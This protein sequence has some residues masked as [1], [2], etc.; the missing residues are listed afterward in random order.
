MK[1]LISLILVTLMILSLLPVGVLSAS[2]YTVT[3]RNIYGEVYD[4][5]T[6]SDGTSFTLPD[7]PA[8]DGMV[9][10]GWKNPSGTK[11]TGSITVDIDYDLTAMYQKRP[12][13]F[14]YP[15]KR[16]AFTATNM[17]VADGYI[18]DGGKEWKRMTVIGTGP[19]NNNYAFIFV[20]Y[21]DIDAHTYK[22]VAIGY[23]STISTSYS[24]AIGPYLAN[25]GG[26]HRLWGMHPSFTGGNKPTKAV[27]SLESLTGGDG[28]VGFDGI[29]AD[30]IIQALR[31]VPWGN[32]F[33]R[34][35]YDGET[36]DIEYI[37]FFKTQEEAEA[38]EYSDSDVPAE[39]VDKPF[40]EYATDELEFRPDDYLTRAEA[41]YA[42]KSI[43]GENKAEYKSFAATN[44][45]SSV[46]KTSLMMLIDVAV[47]DGELVTPDASFIKGTYVT[48]AEAAKLLSLADGRTPTAYGISYAG[49]VGRLS[50]VPVEHEYFSYIMEACFEHDAV[51]DFDNTELWFNVK[52]NNVYMKKADSGLVE[53]LNKHM[54]SRTA[55][56]LA[57]ESEWTLGSGGKVIY[58]S[59]R[60][61]DSNDGLSS[62]APV[63]TLD[64]VMEMQTDGQIVRGDVVLFERGGE[65]Y[66]GYSLN[67]NGEIQQRKFVTKSGVTYSA[68]GS[69][70]KPII[71][72]SFQAAGADNWT[73]V[74]GYDDLWYFNTKIGDDHD[75]GN[76]VFNKGTFTYA[77]EG[78]NITYTNGAGF[79]ARVIK[80]ATKDVPLQ[81]GDDKDEGAGGNYVASNGNTKW[82]FNASEHTFTTS[83]DLAAYAE[84]IPESDLW[85][86]HNKDES[87]LYMICKEGN[88][89][90]VFESIDL[91][92][93]GHGVKVYSGVT[94]DNLAI[95][96]T[97]SHGVSAGSC[98]NLTVRNCE[99]GYIGGSISG[100]EKS[101]STGR[102]GNAVEIYGR[103]DGYYVYNNYMYQC[104]DCG[105][106]VQAGGISLKYNDYAIAQNIDIYDNVLWNAALEVWFTT[107]ENPYGRYYAALINCKLRDNLVAFNGYGFQGY[108][109]QNHAYC[110]FYGASGT[111]ADYIDCVMENNTFWN[112]RNYVFKAVPTTTTPR[113]G[114][115]WRN[116]KIVFEYG[117]G[118]ALIGYSPKIREG[119]IGGSPNPYTNSE[120]KQILG[121]NVLGFNEFYYTLKPGQDDPHKPYGDVNGDGEITSIDLVAIVRGIAGWSEYSE[122]VLNRHA[123]V[124]NNGV[125]TSAD[126]VI[127]ARHLSGWTGYAFL[128]VAR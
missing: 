111:K 88:P 24:W 31:M 56:V 77:D 4:T 60:G 3:L 79:G 68:Y 57:T 19:N 101:G 102:F 72:G 10:V 104:F 87:R 105:P 86:H 5:K 18:T 7:A 80:N 2:T 120:L 51:L 116:N 108:T 74:E 49:S 70:D 25:N 11:L 115:Y 100:L 63:A 71:N 81:M 85:Y 118:F 35:A 89:G 53:N 29:D 112:M 15:A 41:A 127:L 64:K 69:G 38:Y 32:A 119:S 58:V 23:R 43:T 107:N 55:E 84:E 37:A 44:P 83:T 110:G 13:Y 33:T 76:I 125:V 47:D 52:D 122:Y 40:M 62:S 34:Y 65:W 98:S 109:H 46:T 30:S 21:D 123:D 20:P 126:A 121:Y 124:D 14:V 9:H 73:K 67:A 117:K 42:L 22:Y 39:R 61:S 96:F 36:L 93:R 1:R 59:N 50:D 16:L 92:T 66:P 106:T 82:Y 45:S 54:K 6:V 99:V 12:E 113:E 28:G 90:E 91:C 94:L 103:A 114:F 97:G 48:R 17:D 26:Y 8:I 75:I 128:P 27:A 78:V 95:K